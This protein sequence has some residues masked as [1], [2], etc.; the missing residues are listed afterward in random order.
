MT[1]EQEKL[2]KLLNLVSGERLRGSSTGITN[3][4]VASES[5]KGRIIHSPSFKRL[6]QKTQVFPLETNAAVRSR[7]THSIEVAQIGRFLA[8]KVLEKLT[9]QNDVSW[10][11]DQHEKMVAFSN[12]VENACLLHDIGNPAFGHFGED[13]IQNWFKDNSDTLVGYD[14]FHCFDGNPQGFRLATYQSGFDEF[15]LN[16]TVSCIL[17]IVK[18]PW[19]LNNR[20]K[21]KKKIGFFSSSEQ[22]YKDACKKLQWT[23]GH[24]FPFMLLM[25]AADDISNAMGDLEDAIE[26]EVIRI[27]QFDSLLGGWKDYLFGD[28][29]TLSHKVLFMTFKTSFIRKAVDV[30]ATTFCDK[31]DDILRGNGPEKLISKQDDSELSALFDKIGEIGKNY[32]YS[33]RAVERVELFGNAVFQGLLG[34]FGRLFK[35]TKEDFFKLIDD[36]KSRKDKNP[37]LLRLANRMS[38][39]RRDQYLREQSEEANKNE[40]IARAHFIVDF[41]SGMTD[42]FSVETYQFLE[43]IKL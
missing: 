27:E 18:Y 41:V 8:Q 20:P 5:D 28:Y 38:K 22:R 15:G 6:Q 36:N 43:G 13:S 26:N 31:F 1:I 24:P 23:E 40:K 39:S 17:S 12:T 25:D 2:N 10:S 14:D 19:S 30:A 33:H 4:L 3:V 32:I 34:N 9:S 16:L 21:D 37:H 29:E 7:L 11:R 35:L 42:D